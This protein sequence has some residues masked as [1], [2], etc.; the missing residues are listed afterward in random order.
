MYDGA[1]AHHLRLLPREHLLRAL[2]PLYLG[3]VASLVLGTSSADA[4]AMEEETEAMC[5]AFESVK[6][7][8]LDRWDAPRP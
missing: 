1:V 3:R 2:I 5:G 4:V 6:P 7:Y 8:L